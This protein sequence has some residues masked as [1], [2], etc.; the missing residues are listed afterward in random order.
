MTA[1]AVKADRAT[2]RANR[3]ATAFSDGTPKILE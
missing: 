1:A 3:P 2:M